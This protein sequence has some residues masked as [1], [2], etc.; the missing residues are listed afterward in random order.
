MFYIR[1]FEELKQGM[2][3]INVTSLGVCYYKNNLSLINLFYNDNP[4]ASG[5]LGDVEFVNN[6]FAKSL[7]GVK[8]VYLLSK[9]FVVVDYNLENSFKHF[10]FN[11]SDLN[12]EDMRGLQ[13]YVNNLQLI[14]P[15]DIAD[16]LQMD[17]YSLCEILEINP[18]DVYNHSYTIIEMFVV[19]NEP[20]IMEALSIIKHRCDGN[21][22]KI[23][24]LL[25]D[26]YKS[27]VDDII[28]EEKE[29]PMKRDLRVVFS[30]I[31]NEFYKDVEGN[32]NLIKLIAEVPVW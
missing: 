25:V 23:V 13:E 30:D 11:Y 24:K 7:K 8:D 3:N 15:N 1:D 9:F 10:S 6:K 27:K 20:P 19:I 4:E 32:H 16:L 12:K 29:Q 26:K 14:D 22:K 18:E 17:L 28:Q 21:N 5:S 31:M 2:L